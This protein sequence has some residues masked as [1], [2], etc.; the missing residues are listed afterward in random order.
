MAPCS[1][2]WGFTVTFEHAIAGVFLVV[3]L[4]A[5]YGFWKIR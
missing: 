3:I 1:Q 5:A 4:G 2:R